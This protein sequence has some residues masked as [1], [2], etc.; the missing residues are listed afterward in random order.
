ML[1]SFRAVAA[2]LVACM[3]VPALAQSIQGSGSTFAY[4]IVAKWSQAYLYARADGGDFV[5]ND[6][7]VDYEPIGSLGGFLRLNQPEI[8]F[9]ATE[10]PVSPEE[11]ERRKLV[12]FPFV[13]GGIVPVINLNGV[14]PG[15]LKLTGALLA[16]V[17]LGKIQSWA[18]PAIKAL[19][20]DLVIPDRRIVVIHRQ[21]G[22]GSTFNWTTF[23]SLA[24]PEWK[25]KYGADTL[26]SWPLGTGAKG[27]SGMVAAVRETEG[28]I[29]YVEY[30]QMMR[31]QLSYALVRNRAG[32]FVRPDPASFQAA[33]NGVD[34]AGAK[35]FYVSLIDAPG[36]ESY[37]ITA[38]TF[39]VMHRAGRSQASTDRVLRF[40]QFALERGGPDAAA[41]GY[42]P[43]PAPLVALV[44]GYWS[45]ALDYG[46]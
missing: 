29:G 35:D 22:S 12:Q 45:A 39:A 40:F 8:D 32:R 31:A 11:L 5:P 15:E 9:A 4:P 27:S 41:L 13:I 33:A 34:W 19:N 42:V 10:T 36:E 16:D 3:S 37:P 28:A 21:D 46:S 24:S 23:L 20:P 2:L 18:D 17:Y 30:G 43:L 1:R 14:R 25:S 26:V 38:A 7:G 6:A 44:R